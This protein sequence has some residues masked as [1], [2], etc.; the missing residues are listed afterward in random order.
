MTTV[1]SGG[2]VALNNPRPMSHPTELSA[3]VRNGETPSSSSA[4]SAR[5]DGDFTV[6]ATP[7]VA[8]A[9]GLPDADGEAVKNGSQPTVFSSTQDSIDGGSAATGHQT[10]PDSQDSHMADVDDRAKPETRVNGLGKQH[11]DETSG[12]GSSQLLQLSAIAAAQG[13]MDQDAA[14]GSRKRTANGE[15]KAPSPSRSP[16]KGH[17]RSASAISMGSTGSHIGDVCC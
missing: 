4:S 14:A 11:G 17:V 2:G 12:S 3:D 9:R 6:P 5:R 16:V 15:V 13:R 10:I 7:P 1:Y 8:S